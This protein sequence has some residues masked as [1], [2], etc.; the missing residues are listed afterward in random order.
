MNS[1]SILHLIFC[2]LKGGSPF[3]RH[4]AGSQGKSILLTFLI[5]F[6]ATAS[7]AAMRIPVPP[8]PSDFMNKYCARNPAPAA[9][10]EAVLHGSIVVNFHVVYNQA[11]FWARYAAF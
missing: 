5:V 7:L 1:D 8:L 6:S 10:V 3:C 2:K 4:G 11:I 9:S